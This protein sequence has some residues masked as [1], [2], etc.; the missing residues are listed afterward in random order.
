MISVWVV[1]RPECA[2]PGDDF[3]RPIYNSADRVLIFEQH[4]SPST[5]A[6]SV[7]AHR[8]ACLVVCKRCAV[9]QRELGIEIALIWLCRMWQQRKPCM[10]Q[11]A[12]IVGNVA[13]RV[14]ELCNTGLCQVCEG[15]I[16]KDAGIRDVWGIWQAGYR[17]KLP[18]QGRA[19]P[20]KRIIS[21][22]RSTGVLLPSLFSA[23]RRQAMCVG[24]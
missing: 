4:G 18:F 11:I 14:N 3:S 21:G 10:S 24:R 19:N 15:L 2:S 8:P 22:L 20:A 16:M 6:P 5:S 12:K 17:M 9:C 1:N 23:A 13:L 7:A